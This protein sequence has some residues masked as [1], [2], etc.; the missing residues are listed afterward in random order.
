MS[1]S[2]AE[3]IGCLIELSQLGNFMMKVNEIQ[4]CTTQGCKGNLAPVAV[5]CRGPGGAITVGYS[6]D[7]CNLKVAT[8]TIR[9]Y[10]NCALLYREAPPN[11]QVSQPSYIS[12]SKK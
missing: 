10:L 11:L 4:S 12:E 6:C 8:F 2:F 9:N 5:K 1:D 3:Y 7:G